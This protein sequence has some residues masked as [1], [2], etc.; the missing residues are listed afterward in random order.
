M[1]VHT[2]AICAASSRVGVTTSMSG[3]FSPLAWESPSIAGSEN[4]AVLPVPVFA[5]AMMS[6]PSSTSGM[7][8]SCTG[9][10]VV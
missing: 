4:A 3:P 7:A 6:R 8:F 5:A 1:V 9:V 2:S 10:G